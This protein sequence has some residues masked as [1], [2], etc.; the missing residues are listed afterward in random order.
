MLII[1]CVCFKP[2]H[3]IVFRRSLLPWQRSSA[4]ALKRKGWLLLWQSRRRFGPH[5]LYFLGFLSTMLIHI[6]AL[7][8]IHIIHVLLYFI[9]PS[10]LLLFLS[11]FFFSLLSSPLLLFDDFQKSQPSS[12]TDMVVEKHKELDNKV[13][14]IKN[15]VQVGHLA[16]STVHQEP[17]AGR[18]SR[19]VQ[20][21][22]EAGAGRPSSQVHSTQRGTWSTDYCTI[23]FKNFHIKLPKSSLREISVVVT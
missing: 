12:Q 3:R 9:S 23:N 18:P 1:H 20:R 15:R 8:P 16:R 4:A 5:F 14:D 13:R 22:Q 2:P 19:Q 6:L 10:S 17:C 21:H 11:L 7:C